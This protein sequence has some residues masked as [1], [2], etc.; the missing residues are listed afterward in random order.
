MNGRATIPILTFILL[1][2]VAAPAATETLPPPARAV[3]DSLAAWHG[4]SRPDRVD[5]LAA[6]AIAAA[7]AENDS[8][9]LLALL[10]ARGRTRAAFGLAREGEPDLREA[11]ELA[12]ARRDTAAWLPSLRWLSVA[13]GQQGRVTEARRI[14]RDLEA[15]A[16]AA[17]DSVH[18]GWAWI[19]LAYDHYL[20]S[21][22]DS[23]GALYGA[24]AGVLDRADISRGAIWALNG[25]GLA[26]RQAGRYA[27]AA[28]SF[29]RLLDLA[30]THGDAL[31]EA[32]ALNQ[33]GRLEL[34]FGD[35]GRAVVWLRQAEEIHRRFRHHREQLLAEID[36]AKALD[37]QGRKDD[38]AMALDA[39]LVRA[40]EHGLADI[41][42]LASNQLADIFLDRGRPGAAAA[43]T[44]RAL[45][46]PE[47]PSVMASTELGLRL[48]R[49][50]AARDS[51]EAALAVLDAAVAR[52]AGAVSL[53]LR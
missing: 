19:G 51:A 52:G 45:A 41:V 38:A 3:L 48:A 16:T 30:R 27:E 36:I 7:R 35:P 49:A 11:R 10:L 18:M 29:R 13:V 22:P 47:S 28:A 44:R 43:I 50:L 8:T 26:L 24:A 20:A 1:I 34:Y 25:Q 32:V 6:P 5:S 2:L 42:A 21:R 15:L 12:V 14:Y 39:V 31:N 23:A 37:L 4:A 53:E 40:R 33:L 17:G 46:M 9:F